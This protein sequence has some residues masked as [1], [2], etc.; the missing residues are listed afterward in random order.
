MRGITGRVWM[1]YIAPGRT[2]DEIVL[3]RATAIAHGDP[4]D[5]ASAYSGVCTPPSNQG[6]QS[7]VREEQQ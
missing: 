4:D 2:N 3:K 6:C 1:R 7:N 5:L